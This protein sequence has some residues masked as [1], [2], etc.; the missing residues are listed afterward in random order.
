MVNVKHFPEPSFSLHPQLTHDGLRL[1]IVCM[2]VRNDSA[3]VQFA[4][5]EFGNPAN[6]W[7]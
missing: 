2:T 3:G 1:R 4:E 6:C 7:H 5:S